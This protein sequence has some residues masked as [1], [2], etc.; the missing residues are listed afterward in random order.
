MVGSYLRN[1]LLN[2]LILFFVLAGMV[3]A[4]L[5]PVA[6][7]R[8]ATA[9]SGRDLLMWSQALLLL[10]LTTII[11]NLPAV[12]QA[13][14]VVGW[15]APFSFSLGTFWVHVLV[16]FPLQVTAFLLW[17]WWWREPRPMGYT[18]A[19]RWGAESYAALWSLGWLAGAM[20][21]G[22]LTWL[23][24]QL[25]GIRSWLSTTK[26][27]AWLS[28][29][30]PWVQK[31]LGPRDGGRPPDDLTQPPGDASESLSG[32]PLKSAAGFVWIVFTAGVAGYLGGVASVGLIKAMRS[33][34]WTAVH[35][36]SQLLRS[37]STAVA[38]PAPP[39]GGGLNDWHAAF[40]GIPLL[41]GVFLLV[42][43]LHIGL[44]G[45]FFSEA[46]REWWARVGG[47]LLLWTIGWSLLTF[48]AL[49][50]PYIFR[51]VLQPSGT[52]QQWLKWGLGALWAAIT[53]TGVYAGSSSKTKNGGS[54]TALDLAGKIAPHVFVLGLLLLIAM[55]VH[56]WVPGI[57]ERFPL[58][59]LDDWVSVPHWAR[60]NIAPPREA[61][62]YW[63]NA[64]LISNSSPMLALLSLALALVLAARIGINDFSMHGFYR[65]RL[66]RCYF[67][68]QRRRREPQ[69]FTG[70]DPE[71]DFALSELIEAT[72]PRPGVSTSQAGWMK[73]K[74]AAIR[75]FFWAETAAE[76]RAYPGPFPIFNTALNLVAGGELGWQ[77]RKAASF[78]MTPQ[79]CGYDFIRAQRA[80]R[81]SV[82]RRTADAPISLG[83]AVATSGAAASP[84]M[85]YHSSPPLAFLM[86]VFNVRLGWWLG[87]PR[88]PHCWQKTGPAAGLY[89]LL[90]ELLGQ[91]NY[92]RG[93][94]YL[95]DGGHFENLGIYELVR[96][97][98]RYIVACDA[99]E[100]QAMTFSDLGNAIEKCRTDFGVDLEIDV[101]QLRR[102]PESGKSTWHCAVGQIHYESRD[103][104]AAPGTL[105]YL[106]SSLTGDEPT[107][108]QRYAAEHPEFPHQTTADQFFDESQFESY[109]M[110][111]QHVAESVF[112]CLGAERPLA[113]M[114]VRNFFVLLSQRWYPP[115]AA[116]AKSFTQ[117]TAEYTSLMDRMRENPGL[118][119]LDRQVYPEWRQLMA[120]RPAAAGSPDLQ[121]DDRSALWLPPSE[122]ERREGFYFCNEVIQLMED[123]YVDLHLE[124]EFDH[125]DNRG[126]MNLF[127]HWSGS[128]MF[129][130]T[131]AICAGIY[132]ARFQRFC[133]RHLDLHLGS[134]ELADPVPLGSLLEAR[135]AHLLNYWEVELL[136]FFV[137]A[138]G[139]QGSDLAVI[140]LQLRVA[141]PDQV[142]NDPRSM[143]FT[144]GFALV[145][146][147]GT[148]TP[149]RAD[150]YYFRIQNHLRR[151]GLGQAALR[152]LN[153][154]YAL[155][156]S[157][158]HF[159]EDRRQDLIAAAAA[160]H[161]AAAA[162]REAVPS[163][164]DRRAFERLFNSLP[165]T[166]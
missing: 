7:F 92:E 112:G 51:E 141:S 130:A 104:G 121:A 18:E 101:R 123:A 145:R 14:R 142:E 81:V 84:N 31:W 45:S 6:A 91:T 3:L 26:P 149:P 44:V 56:A 85:G 110:L 65:N 93:F 41:M 159:E 80:E 163:A 69:P 89:Y 100:D 73:R 50:A 113:M 38:H 79:F 144:V 108:V 71:D 54:K 11:A 82:F 140:A 94:V 13:D 139:L 52:L 12:I 164:E 62:G 72:V 10:A 20:L 143:R 16:I 15:K 46:T 133:E 34:T 36:I 122:T 33:L 155:R 58:V 103:P 77:K 107:D 25:P 109:R 87:N 68:A 43:T 42:E 124:E 4:A 157:V 29:K 35:P 88:D 106:K 55:G 27:V 76:K 47:L 153:Q 116:V 63:R 127:R 129:C 19:G 160:R 30:M 158:L 135:E 28:K 60:W 156:E 39:F 86:T 128:G 137:E 40:W 23:G 49:D 118:A 120:A 111:G 75:S 59:R 132:G 83:L 22:P 2:Q 154:R 102:T 53:G 61:S 148:A 162:L 99:G 117:H 126:W 161:P 5:I 17:A 114:D 105:V 151:M 165:H 134:L 32:S 146:L 37:L 98:C 9:G 24:Q 48:L 90:L 95:S 152:A 66:V 96:R 97:G 1:L 150:I 166:R 131:W 136:R 57:L 70:F 147:N 78:V 115:S 125:P 138:A 8:A 21:K 74:F 67:G 64:L 119:F